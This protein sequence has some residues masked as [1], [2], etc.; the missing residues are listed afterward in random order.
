LN[1]SITLEEIQFKTNDELEGVLYIHLTY[2]IRKTNARSNVVIPAPEPGYRSLRLASQGDPE[3]SPRIKSG[4]GSG[5]G[6]SNQ[7]RDDKKEGT[8]ITLVL[9]RVCK[10]PPAFLPPSRET[11]GAGS[12]DRFVVGGFLT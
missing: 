9:G 6:R 5:D 2:T 8:V 12:D 3:T 10:V 1:P 7:V 4:A 11:R